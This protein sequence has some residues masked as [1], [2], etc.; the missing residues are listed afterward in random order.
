MFYI[1]VRAC[2]KYGFTYA[3]GSYHGFSLILRP[4]GTFENIEI[5]Q[6]FYECN[7]FKLFWKAIRAMKD[8]RKKGC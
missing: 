6:G 1:F 8:Y 2:R 3:L 4:N 5:K 7:Y